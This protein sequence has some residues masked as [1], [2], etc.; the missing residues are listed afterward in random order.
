MVYFQ[1]RTSRK[2]DEDTFSND[3]LHVYDI[4]NR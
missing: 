1:K 4:E 2:E 3:T